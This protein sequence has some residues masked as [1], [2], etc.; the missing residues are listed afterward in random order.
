MALATGKEWSSTPRSSE[1]PH[2]AVVDSGTDRHRVIVDSA[3]FRTTAR[4]RR[5][6][7]YTPTQSGRR[8]RVV[9]NDRTPPTSTLVQTD[10]EWSSTPRSSE[11]QPWSTT[12]GGRSDDTFRSVTRGMPVG[13]A[14]S[15][16]SGGSFWRK[17][18]GQLTRHHLC[19]PWLPGGKILIHF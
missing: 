16:T 14:T 6:L 1:R 8:L 2:A 12:S 7:W 4:R 13:G 15:R 9:Q 17:T 10:R 18:I 5:R 3:Q 19:V 11:R